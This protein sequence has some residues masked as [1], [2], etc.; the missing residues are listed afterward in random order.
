MIA[1]HDDI[2]PR[3]GKVM[4]FVPSL[5]QGS[6]QIQP[7]I[8]VHYRFFLFLLAIGA[9]I[10]VGTL[11]DEKWSRWKG[12]LPLD[13]IIQ[14]VFALGI[15]W[16]ACDSSRLLRIEIFG[17][18]IVATGDHVLGVQKGT[19]LQD[20]RGIGGTGING[21]GVGWRQIIFVPGIEFAPGIEFV[22]G[23]ERTWIIQGWSTHHRPSEK[24]LQRS[25]KLNRS[26]K[27]HNTTTIFSEEGK[28]T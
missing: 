10:G 28:S 22:L 9:G 5:Q 21:I 13:E 14:R 3:Q 27:A 6:D 4:V 15:F 18:L 1:H 2:M 8:E 26:S 11:D 24:L 23:I 16:G 12:S 7:E 20:D 25:W 19:W 17:Y